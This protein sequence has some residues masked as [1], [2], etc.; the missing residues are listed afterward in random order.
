MFSHCHW[1][2]ICLFHF[3]YNVCTFIFIFQLSKKCLTF[4]HYIFS[5]N[6]VSKCFRNCIFCCCWWFLLLMIPVVDDSCCWWFLLLMIPVIDY[7]CCWWFL[8]QFLMIFLH[9]FPLFFIQYLYYIFT[10]RQQIHFATI[11]NQSPLL[12]RCPMVT[13]TLWY[14]IHNQTDCLGII[15]TYMHVNKYT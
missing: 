8:L 6:L 15:S 12:D 5:F 3:V 9:V 10:R 7:S 14:S 11:A 13:R 2:S 1:N 4:F